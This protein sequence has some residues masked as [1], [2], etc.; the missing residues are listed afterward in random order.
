MRSSK[1]IN[2]IGGNSSLLL[3]NAD[4]DDDDDGATIEV[5]GAV[6]AVGSVGTVG[7]ATQNTVLIVVET[8]L[9]MVDFHFSS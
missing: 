3:S 1:L 6:E 8:S 4:E 9:L 2:L 7:E 5:V